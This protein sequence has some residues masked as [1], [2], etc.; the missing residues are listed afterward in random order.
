M[1]S[2]RTRLPAPPVPPE[3]GECCGSGCTPC[4]F[5]LYEDALARYRALIA[6]A[7]G[8]PPDDADASGP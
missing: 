6:E 5:D 2:N 1:T 4:V 3:P 8:H 7:P